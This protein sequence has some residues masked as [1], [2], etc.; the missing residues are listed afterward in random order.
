MSITEA[1]R[2]KILLLD[3]A[4]GSLIQARLPAYSGLADELVLTQ[5]HVI[6][7]VHRA[8]LDAGADCIT[9]CSFNSHGRRDV[10]IAAARLARRVADEYTERTGVPRFVLG[11]VGPTNRMLSMS[12]DMNRP[13]YRDLTFAELRDAYRIQIQALMEGGADAVLIET[14]TDTL[15][16]KAAL[17]AAEDYPVLISMTVSDASGRILSGQTIEAFVES[18]MFARPL[19]IGLNCGYGAEG[20]LPWL[21]QMVRAVNGRCAV[22][23]HPNAGL[24]NAQGGYDDT[25]EDMRRM[26]APMVQEGWVRMIG[27]CCGTT[28]AH[29]AAL[30]TLLDDAP[31]PVKMESREPVTTYAGLDL[32]S[33][34][35]GPSPVFIN[36]GE[37]CNVAGSRK[38]LRLISEHNYDEALTIAR[39]QVEDGA[40]VLDLNLDDGML[41]SVLEMQTFLRLMG[42]DPDIARVPVMIDSSRWEVIERGLENVQGKP[43]V[44]SISL[45]EGEEL[46]LAHARIIRRFGAA[47]VVMLFDEQGQA[48][49][50][51]RRIAIAARAHHLLTEVIGLAEE[52]IIFD[53][54]VL[55]VATGM[56][57]HDRYALDFIRATEWI[58]SHYPACRISGGVSNLS[59]AFRGQNYLREA[60]HAVFLYHAI[61]AGLSMAIL[62]PASAVQYADI[63]LP[64]REAIE[65]VVLARNPASADRLLDLVSTSPDTPV[66][67]EETLLHTPDAASQVRLCLQRGTTEGLTEAL[68]SLL[69]SGSR[70]LDIISGPLMQGMQEVGTLF[71]EGKMFLPQVVKTARTMRR[72][73]DFLQP[74]MTSETSSSPTDSQDSIL[75]ATVRGDVHDIGKNIVSVVLQCNGYRVIDLGVNVSAEDIVARAEAERVDVV[76]LSGL[77]TPSLEEMAIVAQ[78]ME[79]RGLTCPLFVG[80]ATTSARHTELKLQPLYRGGVYHMTDAS[81][82]PIWAHKLLYGNPV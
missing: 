4:M 36:V 35:M 55:T 73:T 1:L 68:Q 49:D 6:A 27:G 78:L 74:F 65:D 7:Q 40:M 39:R 15:N 18:V 70:P 43:I 28:P 79:R 57:E 11:D 2:H 60:M 63:P 50:Y 24:P 41:D 76:C 61:R 5:P 12:P 82:N 31:L 44:N 77:I 16:V 3:G 23:C 10:N 33:C 64:L 72:A 51:E 62:N 75:I 52:D 21:R 34:P 9:T 8:Y 59:F 46:F 26:M 66:A 22:T 37:R 17:Q 80:G 42:A 48:T 45:K 19:A 54:N 67:A 14:A 69:D 71:G 58:H 56:P 13:E 38:F 47:V 30:R 20:V 53:P 81:Q 29:I 32:L 25:P